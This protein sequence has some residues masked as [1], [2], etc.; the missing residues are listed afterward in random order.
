MHAVFIRFQSSAREE[1][2]AEPFLQ[3]AN[4]LRGGA[5]PGFCAKTWLGNEESM[6]GFHMFENSEAADRYLDTMFSPKV[7]ANPAFTNIRIER[8]EVDEQM[9]AITNGLP[10]RSSIPVQ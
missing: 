7:A 9:S 1:D 6:A 10:A 5:V 3:Y 2:L 8:Y 4:A